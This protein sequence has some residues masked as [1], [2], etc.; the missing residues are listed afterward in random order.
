MYWAGD[1]EYGAQWKSRTEVII[2]WAQLTLAI[3]VSLLYFGATKPID[4]AQNFHFTAWALSFYPVICLLRLAYVYWRA[5]QAIFIFL[6]ALI[7]V[8]LL[9]VIIHHFSIIYGT[10]EASLKAPTFGFYFIIITIHAM[11]FQPLLTLGVGA[12]SAVG[13]ALLVFNAYQA[14]APITHS[15]LAYVNGGQ[16]LFGA[17]IE[18]V[19]GLFGFSTILAITTWR[20]QKL[21][22]KASQAAVAKSKF[23]ATM[24]HEI[25]TPMNGFLGMVDILGATELNEKQHEYLRIMRYSGDSLLSLIND[26]LDISKIEADRMELTQDIFDIRKL[27]ED[28][29]VA[30]TAIAASKGVELLISAAPG[31][32][33]SVLGDP[34][35]LR[36]VLNNLI[37][38]AIKFTESGYVHVSLEIGDNGAFSDITLLVKDT[39]IGIPKESLTSVFNSFEQVDNT[40]TR[41]HQGTGLGLSIVD[42]LVRAMDGAISLSSEV[43]EGSK[44]TVKLKLR[45]ANTDE[46][47]APAN[48]G[49]ALKGRRALIVDDLPINQ[50]IVDRILQTWGVNCETAGSG[51][52]ALTILKSDPAFDFILLDFQMPLMG[53]RMTAQKIRKVSG[54]QGIPI[55]LMTAIDE[56]ASE[57]ELNAMDANGSIVK[58]VRASALYEVVAQCIYPKATACKTNSDQPVTATAPMPFLK[59]NDAASSAAAKTHRILLAEDNPVNRLVMQH[60]L[61]ESPYELIIAEDG[62]AVVELFRDHGA[63]LVLMDMSMPRMDGLAAT[64]AIRLMEAENKGA[65]TRTPILGVT[66]HAAIED[67]QAAIKAGMDDVLTK[68]VKRNLLIRALAQWTADE[69]AEPLKMA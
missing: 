6:S 19:F 2:G 3:L 29:C 51:E 62:L 63:D 65:S 39:G 44:F 9:T 32:H 61:N 26:V 53:G 14:G 54:A 35:R 64:H 67:R 28:I 18:K 10:W 7:D 20:A 5:P 37:N 12:A 25:R 59:E 30:N 48:L 38:N 34:D 57:Q 13:W 23:L 8:V 47:S 1:R 56:I 16:L 22:T 11:R 27:V 4:L 66:A 33:S 42:R 68:P 58:P 31:A 52:E 69:C 41:T 17:E 50:K 24:S 15:Y 40:S 43:G 49:E 55:L 45:T 60:M 46:G 36:Q 21:L